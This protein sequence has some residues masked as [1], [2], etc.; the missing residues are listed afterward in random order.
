MATDLKDAVSKS[1][2]MKD[3][4]YI[5]VLPPDSKPPEPVADDGPHR[6]KDGVLTRAGMAFAIKQGGSVLF[7][8]TD[9]TGPRT[10]RRVEDLPNEEQVAAYIDFK[11]KQI[12]SIGA[13]K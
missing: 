11:T 8:A 6:T 9:A 5:S 12:A 10:Y 3:A 7:D 2:T 4:K 1:P 13:S